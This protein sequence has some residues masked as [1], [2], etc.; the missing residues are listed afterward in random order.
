MYRLDVF[1][2]Q[3]WKISQDH[4]LTHATRQMLQHIRDGDACTDNA[5]FTATRS[6]GADDRLVRDAHI[7]ALD[8]IVDILAMECAPTALRAV[9]A[10]R[11]A[12]LDATREDGFI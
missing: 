5:R 3:I 6:W 7:P 4:F 12:V 10:R 8:L 1:L 2:R 11:A 9:L